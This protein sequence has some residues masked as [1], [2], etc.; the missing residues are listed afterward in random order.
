VR[1]DNAWL[2]SFLALLPIDLLLPSRYKEPG[3]LNDHI[4]NAARD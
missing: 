2:G 1:R 4:D 3:A